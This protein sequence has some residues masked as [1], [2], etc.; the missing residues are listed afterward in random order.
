LISHKLP[1]DLQTKHKMQLSDE[2]MLDIGS[3]QVQGKIDFADQKMSVVGGAIDERG[4]WAAKLQ[5]GGTSATRSDDEEGGEPLLAKG[6]MSGAAAG[7]VQIE[8]VKGDTDFQLHKEVGLAGRSWAGV[9]DSP[10][11]ETGKKW[12]KGLSETETSGALLDKDHK[13]GLKHGGDLERVGKFWAAAEA[14][15]YKVVEDVKLAQ[16]SNIWGERDAG[17]GGAAGDARVKL[18][19]PGIDADHKLPGI[20]HK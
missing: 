2:R 3:L 9:G 8:D 17:L 19:E 6:M 13:A 12:V 18:G 16:S 14:E 10:G 1:D 7:A 11:V 5:G 20:E 4:V 15:S